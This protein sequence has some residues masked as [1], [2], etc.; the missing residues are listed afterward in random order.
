MHGWRRGRHGIGLGGRHGGRK[1]AFEQGDLRF[2]LLK[3]IAEKPRHGYEIIKAIEETFGGTYSPS[4]GVV[5][6]TLT[7]LEDMGLASV[8]PGEGSKKLYTITP[9]GE[10][11]LADNKPSVDA[12]FARMDEARRAFGGGMA[13]EIRRAMQ[14]FRT[15]FEL[16][17]ERGP[18]SAEEVAKIAAAID[19]AAAEVERS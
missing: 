19:A 13:P 1:R 12:I 2:V 17:L 5:Y 7:L 9:E 14:N 4:P 15:A 3:L 11:F 6:P 10:Q 8:A 16:R 18:L